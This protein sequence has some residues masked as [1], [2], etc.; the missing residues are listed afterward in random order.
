MSRNRKT[1]AII[2]TALAT[3]ALLSGCA[4]AST[5]SNGKLSGGN[6]NAGGWVALPDGR[7]VMC[8][9]SGAGGISCDWERA[10]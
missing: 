5:D 4:G 6:S 8:V 10:K 1:A 7:R 9:A 2:V 3:I